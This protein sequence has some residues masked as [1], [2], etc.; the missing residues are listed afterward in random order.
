MRRIA[1]LVQSDVKYYKWNSVWGVSM[2]INYYNTC[3]SLNQHKF[4]Y[5]V[6]YALQ[7]IKIV[8]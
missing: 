1:I 4:Y 7:L 8:T 3:S 6:I 5:I 2:C